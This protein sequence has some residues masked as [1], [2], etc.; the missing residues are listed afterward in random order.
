MKND[1]IMPTI[2]AV[3]NKLD[4]P[5]PLGYSNIGV[6]T[7]VGDGVRGF[8]V[9]DRVV[10]NGRHAEVVVVPEN[11][12]ARI[13]ESV[14]ADD[15]V[16]TVIAAIGL[17]GMRLAQPT[18]GE[19]V[20]VTGLGLIGL[21][22]VQLLR[23]NGCRV[24]GIDMDAEKLRLAKAFG[25]DVVN[26]AAGEGPVSAAMAFSRGRG[27]DAVL[28]TAATR[29]SEPVHQAALMCRKRGRIVLVGVAGLEL[30]RADFY[31]KE[32]SFQVSCSY[33]PGRYDPQY[34]ERGV[35]YPV[36]FVRWTEQRN[37]EAVLD[38]MADGR[39]DVSP[40]LS[41]RFPISEAAAAY[42]ALSGSAPSLGILLEY[43]TA[44]DK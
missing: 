21:A 12:C 17:Q 42:R 29:S 14:I 24:L 33:G 11:L 34:E 7:A 43:P 36:G 2:E 19:T 10:S 15:A 1:G 8:S 20:V 6:V 28:I 3:M 26:L 22:T 41:H 4:Q 44:A 13:P 39:L 32:L 40:L 18:L 5:L 16:F 27:I 30:S 37:F 25:A 9:G 35:D 38:M 31:E 23:A